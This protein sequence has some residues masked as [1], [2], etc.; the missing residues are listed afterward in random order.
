MP[1]I[2]AC[3]NRADQKL[4]HNIAKDAVASMRHDNNFIVEECFADKSFLASVE[5][6]DLFRKNNPLY[7]NGE[8]LVGVSKGGFFNKDEI[9]QKF[10]ITSNASCTN[11]TRFIVELYEKVGC[12][13]VKYINGLFSVI[14][15]D[16][17]ENRVIVANDRY[18]YFPLFFGVNS[19]RITFA[20]EAKTVLKGLVE[21]P[22]LNE[23]AV[24]EFFAFSFLLGDKT[25]FKKVKKI[26]P[27]H[28]VV[29]EGNQDK[30]NFTR[31]WDF[32][33]KTY[34]RSIPLAD[35][36]KEFNRLM[37]QA[38]ER[39]V[40]DCDKVGVFL[41]GGLDSRV[42]AAFASE[43]TIP[44]VTYT[45]G[46]EGCEEQII[47]AE[48]AEA[49]GLEN[50]FF[51]IPSSFIS[52]FA[53]SIVYTGDGMIRIRD[54]H[55]ISLLESI[56]GQVDS[57]LLGTFGGDLT[58]RPEGRLPNKLLKFR[59][60]SQVI[61]FLFDY[62]TNIVSN[63]LPIHKHHEVFT[64][65]FLS[66]INGK[67]KERFVETFADIPF[68]S[69]T[70]IGDYWE[71]RN[72]EPR[73]IFHASQH[74][75]WF[76]DTRHPYMDNDL[77]DFFAFRFPINLRRKEIFGV[78]FEDTFLQKA[79]N[80]RFPNLSAIT[81]HGFKSDSNVLKVL[82]VKGRRIVQEKFARLLERILRRR[83]TTSTLDF[84]GYADWLRTGSRD[85]VLNTLLDER[86]LKRP[87]FRED[88]I[89]KVVADHLNYRADNNQLLCDLINFEL[90]NR[91][92]FDVAE[93]DYKL[94]LNLSNNLT[95]T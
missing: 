70:D 39:R 34:D 20:S 52:D 47:A 18:G 13:F 93:C 85:F 64:G 2:I 42:I 66:R 94:S 60:K 78:T 69:A 54:S 92:F 75:N 23:D 4:P 68:D 27:A 58:C 31:Y 41:S 51:D 6:A 90:M 55:F 14:I 25:F 76:L 87:Y 26:P 38:I 45:F 77:V 79:L 36:L 40:K 1:G 35:Y 37:K 74:M 22:E 9:R 81:W 32:S 61:D 10:N 50:V 88:F 73:Y 89:R 82:A 19:D 84:R 72:R 28:L 83:V 5:L 48:I 12:D 59:Q 57:V 24:P 44:V 17:K 3:I 43:L 71:Y 46:V 7:D 62:Y 30:F 21:I 15:L 33:L 56:R 80:Q 11:D 63:V 53:N 8:S 65:S 49:L 95:L 67:T 91:I 29:Y 86:S 16:K